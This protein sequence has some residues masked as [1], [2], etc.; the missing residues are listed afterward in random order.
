MAELFV[1]SNGETLDGTN[2]NDILEATGF[3][4]TILNG[5]EGNDELFAGTDGTLNGGVGD[6]ILDATVGGGGN[7]LNGEGGND[8]LFGKESDILD[9]G[10]GTDRLFTDGAG[11]NTYTGGA[12]S[13]QFWLAASDIPNIPN[14]V[15]DFSQ[16]EDVLGIGGLDGTVDSFADVTVTEAGGNTTVAIEN[17]DTPLATLEGFT[18]ELTADDFAIVS[19]D[20]PP[21]DEA[22]TVE[23][24]TFE[25]EE[26]SAV[27]TE[28]GTVTAT[29]AE[30]DDLTFAISGDLDVDGDGEAAFAIDQTGLI[31]VNDSDDIDFETQ[32]SFDFEVTA[33]D[34]NGNIGTG[35]VTVDL[36]NDPADDPEPGELQSDFNG[37]GL[38]NLNDLGVFA[39]AFGTS[40]GD[41]NFNAS[42]DLTGDGLVNLNDLGIFASEFGASA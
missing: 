16:G 19:A 31:T 3:S 33:E 29:D 14:R 13:D 8:T 25:V 20:E 4:G 41:D 27:G 10:E 30:G 11:D 39:A 38:V 18:G 24:A 1:T 21:V 22:P 5:L 12:G 28:V 15:T 6:D 9:A 17:G 37:D 42:A 32:Q 23:E 36:I 7:T 35:N 26:E 2:E 34:T 40:D